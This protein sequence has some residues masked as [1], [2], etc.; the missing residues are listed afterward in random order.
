[1]MLHSPQAKR[2]SFRL[3]ERRQLVLDGL[4]AQMADGFILEI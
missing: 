1:M 2:I 4:D 3:S